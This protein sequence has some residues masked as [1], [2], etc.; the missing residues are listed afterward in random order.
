MKQFFL[1]IVVLLMV[2]IVGCDEGEP[3]EQSEDN[4]EVKEN[5]SDDEQSEEDQSEEKDEDVKENDEE[6]EK[7]EELEFKADATSYEL[8]SDEPLN[9]EIVGETVIID[10]QLQIAGK[11]NL[12]EGARIHIAQKPI[13]NVTFMGTSGY[14]SIEGDGSFK[15]QKE[16]PDDYKDNLNIVMTLNPKVSKDEIQD[17][18]G[19]L[20]ESLEG[21]F[22]R[23][24]YSSDEYIKEVV[25]EIYHERNKDGSLSKAEIPTPTLDKPND[26][27]DLNIRM[28]ADLEY[29]DDYVYINGTSNLIEGT[30]I[31]VSVNKPSGSRSGMSEFVTIK[32]DGS[33]NV[34]FKN[35]S[36]DGS[37]LDY[38]LHLNF[39]I[40]SSNWPDAIE[41]YGENGENLKGDLVEEQYD[42]ELEAVK[43]ITITE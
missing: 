19:E 13:G 36:D 29:D 32:P 39:S 40:S 4:E 31:R 27:G 41:K 35:K 24:D 17:V 6:D 43:M 2:A 10:N 37:L 18:Y 42:G 21:P 14:A 25:A 15:Y 30:D 8:S 11:T 20:G 38:K 16:I 26:Y 7:D 33:F 28:D 23:Q 1:A 5:K 12:P 3:N 9:V 34:I 22:V